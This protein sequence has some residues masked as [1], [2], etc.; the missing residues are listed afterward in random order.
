M[1]M[2]YEQLELLIDRPD[3]TAATL[4]QRPEVR[5]SPPAP[6]PAP[7]PAIAPPEADPPRPFGAWLLAQQDR[8][9]LIGALAKA[10]K[11]DGGFPGR[12]DPDAVRSRLA[13]A[14]AEGDMFEAVDDA[15]AAWLAA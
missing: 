7:A 2:M 8:R 12:G 5:P 4:S 1:D 14:G 3:E 6:V 15:E 13:M 11:A 9:G 10:A